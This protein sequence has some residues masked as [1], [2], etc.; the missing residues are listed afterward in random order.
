MKCFCTEDDKYV[1]NPGIMPNNLIRRSG[2]T[3]EECPLR[4]RDCR[5]ASLL[6]MTERKDGSDESDPYI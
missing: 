4:L 1:F 6:A 5:V 3:K 2:N